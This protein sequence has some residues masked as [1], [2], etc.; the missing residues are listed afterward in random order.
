MFDNQPELHRTI[1]LSDISHG[2]YRTEITANKE[3]CYELSARLGDVTIMH[4]SGIFELKSKHRNSDQA[5][6]L[7]E[8]NGSIDARVGQICVI[9]SDPVE[10]LIQAQF[11]GIAT[12][13]DVNRQHEVSAEVVDDNLNDDDGGPEI[14]AFIEGDSLD[15]G[16]LL[17]EQLALE[18]EP[19]PRKP[20]V[21]FDGYHSGDMPDL[22]DEKPNPFAVLSELKDNRD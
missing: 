10:T 21:S 19:F 1:L 2:V 8:I 15:L 17:V 4:L 11:S 16:N 14:L 5:I 9:T 22:D 13:S 12:L 3:E 20:G 7:I 6:D 18:I